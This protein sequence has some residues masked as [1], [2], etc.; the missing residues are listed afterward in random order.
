MAFGLADDFDPVPCVHRNYQ[1]R[2]GPR[3]A[4]WTVVLPADLKLKKAG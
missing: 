2:S 1:G 4:L 3:A